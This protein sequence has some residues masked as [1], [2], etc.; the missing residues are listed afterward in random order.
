MVVFLDSNIVIY[1]VENPPLFGSRATARL[2]RLRAGGDSFMI[3]DLTR[4]ECSVSPIRS[5]NAA[6]LGQFLAFFA[7]TGVKVVPITA[8]VC[9]RAAQIRAATSFRPM[10]ALH[11][12]AAVTHAANHFLTN[13]T[14]LNAFTGLPVEVLA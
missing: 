10:D 9:D 12:A 6:L 4:M 3:S 2:A 13:D 11:L 14:R 7:A 5:G 8:A 1:A